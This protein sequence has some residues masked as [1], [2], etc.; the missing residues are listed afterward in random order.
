MRKGH[1]ILKAVSFI[2][3]LLLIFLYFCAAAQVMAGIW[4]ERFPAI[5]VL[6]IGVLE[7][8]Q[9]LMEAGLEL[10][11]VAS[12]ARALGDDG[13]KLSEEEFLSSC[14]FTG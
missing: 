1:N 3:R 7:I 8:F 11:H 5:T 13:I 2:S 10:P 14:T 4:G 6:Y 12:L 9:A